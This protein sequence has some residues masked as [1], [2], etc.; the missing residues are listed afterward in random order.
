M[1]GNPPADTAQPSGIKGIIV[2]VATKEKH[3]PSAPRIHNFLFQK[4]RNNSPANS[5]S[6]T[7]RK[8]VAPRIPK[9]GYIQKIRGPL[10]M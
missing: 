8:Y 2:K 6:D 1:A 9:T 3:A 10:L 4:P 5:H 7:P